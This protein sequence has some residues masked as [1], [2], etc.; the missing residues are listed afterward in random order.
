[1]H[2]DGL[3]TSWKLSEYADL[4]GKDPA[5][6]AAALFREARRERDDACVVVAQ[7]RR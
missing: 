3:T 6:I 2:S 1:M 4:L 5:L 7:E